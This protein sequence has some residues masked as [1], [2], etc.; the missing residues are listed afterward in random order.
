MSYKGINPLLNGGMES[1]ASL[2]PHYQAHA[3]GNSSK[4]NAPA[5]SFVQEPS[6]AP[7]TPVYNAAELVGRDQARFF[8]DNFDMTRNPTRFDIQGQQ[9]PLGGRQ[10][11]PI[12]R[13]VLGEAR[14]K[15]TDM[16]FAI[17][18]AA[19]PDISGVYRNPGPFDFQAAVRSGHPPAYTFQDESVQRMMRPPDEVDPGLVTNPI[20]DPTFMA[21]QPQ[22]DHAPEDAATQRWRLQTNGSM[23][24][25]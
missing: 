19:M 25:W 23:R 10:Q 14:A 12:H 21:R 24:F 6:V 1:V 16:S 7:L 22:F 13:P 4:V 17:P 20:P 8:R 5:N 11:F 2:H 15:T 18:P 9:L 3:M